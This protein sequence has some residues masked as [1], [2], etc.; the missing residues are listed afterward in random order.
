M[1]LLILAAG[2]C[3]LAIGLVAGAAGGVLI[4]TGAASLDALERSKND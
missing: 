1:A 3:G 4:A 2:L